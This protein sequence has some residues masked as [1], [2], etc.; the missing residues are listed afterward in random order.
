[1]FKLIY[2]TPTTF[3]IVR[4]DGTTTSTVSTSLPLFFWYFG[5]NYIAFASVLQSPERLYEVQDV[6]FQIT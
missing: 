1:M 3:N 4:P 6:A 5:K 2:P